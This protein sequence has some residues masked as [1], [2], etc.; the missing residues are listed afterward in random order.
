MSKALEAAATV[1]GAS[2]AIREASRAGSVVN[3]TLVEALPLDLASQVVL[4]F[5]RA[6]L[7]DEE[8]R[9]TVG[10]AAHADD[11][12]YSGSGI[13]AIQALI[14]EVETKMTQTSEQALT[15][16]NSDTAA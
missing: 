5:L 3:V 13:N 1:L 6:A 7:E 15:P 9:E 12:S 8:L 4:A 16:L 11:G 10:I 14:D 2:H